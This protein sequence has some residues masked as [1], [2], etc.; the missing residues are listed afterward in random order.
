MVLTAISGL[1]SKLLFLRFK[2][3][4]ISVSTVREK[5]IKVEDAESGEKTLYSCGPNSD[6]G[7]CSSYCA[8]RHEGCDIFS[9]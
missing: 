1:H 4:F 9:A 5:S 7:Y 6:S 2:L 8:S 3:N